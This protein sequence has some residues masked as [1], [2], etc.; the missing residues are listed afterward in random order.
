MRLP[1]T[2]MKRT[3]GLLFGI[4]FGAIA[5]GA[6]L[7]RRRRVRWNKAPE[8]TWA[9]PGMTVT[10]RAE[11]MPGRSTSERTYRVAK[12][13]PQH[14]VQLE[15]VIGEHTEHEFEPV[16]FSSESKMAQTV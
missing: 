3:K 11:L 15:G 13:L 4:T 8:D 12:L 9:R 10:F 2:Q 1:F 7:S 6:T 5:L 16:R 14:R